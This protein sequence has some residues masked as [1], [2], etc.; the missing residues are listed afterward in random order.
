M[1]KTTNEKLSRLAVKIDF[2]ESPFTCSVVQIFP[3]TNCQIFTFL[4]VTSFRRACRFVGSLASHAIS[5]ARARAASVG[6]FT[7]WL[8]GARQNMRVHIPSNNYIQYYRELTHGGRRC[9]L[10]SVTQ[11]LLLRP[12]DEPQWNRGET[13]GH[14][15][16]CGMCGNT[17]AVEFAITSIEI[18]PLA[19]PGPVCCT[20][21]L[22]SYKTAM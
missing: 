7:D 17:R 11:C 21:P 4:S 18:L 14:A 6:L 1:L 22:N 2:A 13:V 9:C 15:A 20:V 10:Q 19:S 3:H 5:R 12:V 16:P 8:A